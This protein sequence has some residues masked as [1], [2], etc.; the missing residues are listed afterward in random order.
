MKPKTSGTIH[1]TRQMT[2]A[3]VMRSKDKS[4]S[5]KKVDVIDHSARLFLQKSEDEQPN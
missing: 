2:S 3:I 4:Q 5:G 1:L